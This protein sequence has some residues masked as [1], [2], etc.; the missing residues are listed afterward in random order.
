MTKRERDLRD[1]K[2]LKDCIIPGFAP[3]AGTL[4]FRKN[5]GNKLGF[6]LVVDILGFE[7]S[8]PSRSH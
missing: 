6:C 2:D 3:K 4:K 7:A 8:D 1:L 5:P